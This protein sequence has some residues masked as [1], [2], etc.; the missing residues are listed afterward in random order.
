V[1]RLFADLRQALRVFRT[2]PGFV[3]AVVAAIALGIG[4]NTA[5]FSVV[6]AVVLKPVPFPEPDRLVHLQTTREGTRFGPNTSPAK[7][8]HWRGLDGVFSDITG[9]MTRVPLNFTQGDV[10]EI[11][12]AARVTESYFRVFGAPIVRGRT[13]LPEEDL[14]NAAPTVVLSH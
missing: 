12:A 14:P 4:T 8:M 6:N 7:F 2:S 5:I 9:F 3:A 1:E 13:F 10:P 11:I